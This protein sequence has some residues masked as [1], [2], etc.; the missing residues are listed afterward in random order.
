M[1]YAYRNKKS[2]EVVHLNHRAKSAF[3]EEV[4]HEEEKSFELETFEEEETTD[5]DP[6]SDEIPEA[7]DAADEP[8]EEAPKK[9]SRSRGKK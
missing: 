4:E 8:A 9:T 5:E 3:W 2:G 7:E 6:L 1:A